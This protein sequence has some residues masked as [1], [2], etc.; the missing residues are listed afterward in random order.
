MMRLKPAMVA[1][2]IVD[3][4][5]STIEDFENRIIK[6]ETGMTDRLFG[7][8]A[9]SLNGKRIGN[10]KW[11]AYSLTSGRGRAAEETRHGADVLGVLNIDLN[12]YKVR[13]GFL[14]QAKI[15]EPHEPISKGEWK[16]FQDQCDLMLQRSAESFGVIYSRTKGVRFIPAQTI[17]EITPDQLFDAGS[18][19]LFGFFKSH[20]KCQIG[21][22]QLHT[23]G[24]E[25][26]DA[27]LKARADVA[28]EFVADEF[29]ADSVLSMKVTDAPS[30]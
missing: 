13:K 3:G 14:L 9:Q 7:A 25:V 16:R 23:P 29:G 18:R 1:R 4:T 27:M 5:A 12:D 20:V 8:V 2:E 19:S 15:A 11:K 26:L 10:L 24:V 30:S 6:Q 28:D 22:R 17:M 21:D